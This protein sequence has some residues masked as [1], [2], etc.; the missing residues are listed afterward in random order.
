M[1]WSLY[2]KFTSC[3][4]EYTLVAYYCLT[5]TWQGQCQVWKTVQDRHQTSSVVQLDSTHCS[6]AQSDGNQ[7]A[8]PDKY[9]LHKVHHLQALLAGRESFTSF[10]LHMPPNSSTKNQARSSPLTSIEVFSDM[11]LLFTISAA[12]MTFQN[13]MESLLQGIPKVWGYS[14]VVLVTGKTKESS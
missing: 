2:L 7:V 12:H 3:S 4:Q 6:G 13:T 9:Q 11:R 5:L 8:V 10:I 14:D 1:S